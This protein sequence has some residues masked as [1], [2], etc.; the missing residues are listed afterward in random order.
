MGPRKRTPAFS[1]LTQT[2]LTGSHWPHR[3]STVTRSSSSIACCAVKG[4]TKR[5]VLSDQDA[6]SPAAKTLHGGPKSDKRARLMPVTPRSEILINPKPSLQ[7]RW[8]GSLMKAI[9]KD[10]DLLGSTTKA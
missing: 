2:T 7:H 8:P 10:I 6:P 9:G 1:P 3:S 5:G 4:Q